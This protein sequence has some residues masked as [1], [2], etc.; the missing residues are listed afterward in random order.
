MQV[1][2]G[3]TVFAGLNLLTGVSFLVFG[4]GC[5]L[6]VRMKREFLRYGLSRFRLLTGGLQLAGG[7]GLL[8]GIWSGPIGFSASLGLAVLMLMG[9]GVR[10]RI[11]DTWLQTTPAIVYCLLALIL[12]FGYL[13]KFLAGTGS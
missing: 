11:G 13:S 5:F 3:F 8:V 10:R 4:S 7:L 6:S 1:V 12:C 2:S 9:I